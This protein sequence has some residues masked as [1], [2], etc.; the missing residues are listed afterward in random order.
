MDSPLT[1]NILYTPDDLPTPEQAPEADVVI[2]DGKCVFCLGQVRNLKKFDRDGQLAFMSLHDPAVA[3]R[4]PDLTYDQMMKQIYVV[5]QSGEQFGGAAAIR[6]LTGQLPKLWWAAPLTHIP[7]T[8]PIQQWFY[9]QVAKR[10]YKIA[11][12]NGTADCD[13]GA[14]A[15]HFGDKKSSS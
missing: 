2:Y 9:D 5:S 13:D 12:K 7:F 3:Q 6:Y 8:L 15:V 1:D 10:R 14:C 4:C 11:N